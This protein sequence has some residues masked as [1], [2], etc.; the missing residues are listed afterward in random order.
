MITLKII[1]KGFLRNR[2]TYTEENIEEESKLSY[3]EYHENQNNHDVN[4][5]I[6]YQELMKI[7]KDKITIFLPHGVTE[8]VL[9]SIKDYN[10]EI[11][12][13]EKIKH[14]EFFIPHNCNYKGIGIF[15]DVNTGLEFEN[16]F[17]PTMLYSLDTIDDLAYT[18]N[19]KIM[20]FNNS[21]IGCRR[22]IPGIINESKAEYLNK[23]MWTKKTSRILQ[24][25]L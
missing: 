20:I 23:F 1:N 8:N 25:D 11:K 15:A 24:N 19:Q 4:I 14:A 3:T 10:F 12:N 9:Y 13:L 18:D 5:K 7:Y 2:I 22:L 16:N 21:S 17:R 6:N